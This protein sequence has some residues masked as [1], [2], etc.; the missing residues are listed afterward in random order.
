[1]FEVCVVVVVLVRE[2][3]RERE[4]FSSDFMK[5]NFCFAK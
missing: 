3:E 1:V 5:S 2:R 4:E